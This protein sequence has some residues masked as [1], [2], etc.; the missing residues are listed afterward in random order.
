[1]LIILIS[2][3][4][5]A[6]LFVK[7]KITKPEYTSKATVFPLTNSGD[8]SLGSGALSGLL[9]VAD[10]SKNFSSE[11]N[12]NII[13]LA[14]SRN[15]RETV[16]AERLPEFGNKTIAELLIEEQNKVLHFWNKK[17]ELPADSTSR[18]VLGGELLNQNITA[19]I[20]KN[21]ILELY[22]TNTNEKL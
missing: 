9:G 15:V 19:K 11:G 21:G 5:G 7:A 14:I 12:V 22:F 13:E 1:M 20:N 18:A 2:L 17:L 16:A 10:A 3:L 6:L 8:N 4:C